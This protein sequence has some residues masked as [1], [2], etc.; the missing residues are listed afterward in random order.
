MEEAQAGSGGCGEEQA[1]GH[2]CLQHI[3]EEMAI[4]AHGCWSRLRGGQ[5]G[6]RS[7]SYVI[8]CPSPGVVCA[9]CLHLLNPHLLHLAIT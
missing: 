4:F 3:K 7:F 2:L 5:A 6:D 9:N 8:L 1:R